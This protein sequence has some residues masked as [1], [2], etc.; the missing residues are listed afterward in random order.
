MQFNSHATNQDLVTLSEKKAKANSVSFPIVEK[1][2]YANQ[3]AKILLS[4]QIEVASGWAV[5]DNN[6]S[7][8]PEATTTLSSGQSLYSVPTDADIIDGFAVKNAGGT[9]TRLSLVTLERITEVMAEDEFFNT[10]GN[11]SCYRLIGNQVQIYPASSYTQTAS[12][13]CYYKRDVVLF[14]TTSTTATPAISSRFHEAVATYMALQYA[15]ANTLA[16]VTELQREWDGN[17][18]VTGKE[19]GYKK[20]VKKF[21]S[22]RLTPM[23]P[24][25]ITV[26]DY[27]QQVL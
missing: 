5:D 27:S 26:D 1:V 7:D 3:A 11:P 13:K 17:E 18:D 8:I 10:S 21:Y 22:Q 14:T 23:N 24:P 16:S 15:K 12:L 9:W 25:R 2:L 19:G 20:A 6:Q 4:W